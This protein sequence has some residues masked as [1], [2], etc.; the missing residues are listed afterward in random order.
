MERHGLLSRLNEAI[1]SMKRL[2]LLALLW[3]VALT[4]GGA[5]S[6]HG[7]QATIRVALDLDGDPTTGCSVALQDPAGP[8]GTTPF[9]GAD[10][11]LHWSVD[12]W[13][14][15]PITA[16][17]SLELCTSLSEPPTSVPLASGVPVAID[18]GFKGSDAIP[19]FVSTGRAAVSTTRSW[20]RRSA[21]R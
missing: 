18:Q 17:A 21:R 2:C 16:D 5:E 15:P 10:A 19:L 14:D 11:T 4:T 20:T 12:A 9:D 3:A 13:P 7:F 6:A 1:G 8:A